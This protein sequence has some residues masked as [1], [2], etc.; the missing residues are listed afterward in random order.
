MY[1]SLLTHIGTI[2]TVKPYNFGL[3]TQLSSVS[4]ERL[5][6]GYIPIDRKSST[7]KLI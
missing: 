3:E 7:L 1:L 6:S 5:R 2:F 4:R